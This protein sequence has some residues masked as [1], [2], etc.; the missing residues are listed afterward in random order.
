MNALLFFLSSLLVA[1]ATLQ[2]LSSL[3]LAAMDVYALLLKRSFRTPRATTII[4]IGGWAMG[5][6]T[7]AAA[8]ASAG[9][10]IL[11]SDDLMLCS[12]NH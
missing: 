1:A 7:C 9:V 11:I 12:E 6:A 2:C 3:T 8:S 5:A 10:T 4:S